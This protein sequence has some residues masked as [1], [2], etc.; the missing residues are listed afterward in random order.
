MSLIL[1][2]VR[3]LLVSESLGLSIHCLLNQKKDVDISKINFVK[4]KK[5]RGQPCDQVVKFVLSASTAQGFASSIRTW[6]RLVSHAEVASHMPQLE[7]PT[8]E[9][10]LCTG[11]LWGEKGKKINKKSLRRRNVQYGL[12][13]WEWE[14]SEREVLRGTSEEENVKVVH[15]R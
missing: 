4:K 1:N 13:C 15:K 14:S 8:T 5:C 3:L 7:G 12:G 11:G 10:K 2:K 6:H 9:N